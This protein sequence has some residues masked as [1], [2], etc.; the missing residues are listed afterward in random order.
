M[1]LTKTTL[2]VLLAAAALAGSHAQ[3][4]A[5]EVTVVQAGA[6]LPLAGAAV[7]QVDFSEARP[8][9]SVTAE[10]PCTTVLEVR[11]ASLPAQ[12]RL[13]ARAAGPYARESGA[14]DARSAASARMGLGARAAGQR[15]CSAGMSSLGAA[16]ALPRDALIAKAT[17]P[18]PS[19]AGVGAPAPDHPGVNGQQDRPAGGAD[20][21]E[22][23]L[24]ACQRAIVARCWA[25]L[26]PFT[27]STH[28]PHQTLLVPLESAYARHFARNGTLYSRKALFAGA[29]FSELHG[30]VRYNIIPGALLAQHACADAC[31]GR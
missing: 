31:S 6:A 20:S 30:Y 13:L 14:P 29:Q 9:V 27:R 23:P 17:H 18:F 15:S 4:V 1:A 8:I 25:A 24:Q 2:I 5:P 21:G 22:R 28:Q 10:P 12:Q 19:S 7:A 26:T 3:V 16:L 11:E